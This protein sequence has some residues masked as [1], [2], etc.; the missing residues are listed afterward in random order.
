MP[1]LSVEAWEDLRA[2][3]EAGASL[4]ELSRLFD[5]DKSR[6]S[7]RARKEGWATP[8]EAAATIRQRVNSRV[9]L[10]PAKKEVA[11]DRA[12]D[13]ATEIV[14]RH[15]RDWVRHHELFT[16]EACAA[17]FDHA[18]RARITAEVLSLRQKGELSAWGLHNQSQEEVEIVIERSY[19]L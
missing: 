7:R 10:D 9:N 12:V 3:R 4:G 13:Q 11:L 19:G 6:I 1:K 5:I 15:R 2:Q 18:K 16:V 8:A 14:V 17:D